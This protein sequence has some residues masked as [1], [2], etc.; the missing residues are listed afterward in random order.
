MSSAGASV[1]HPAHV[2]VAGPTGVG[3]TTA[4]R[5]LSARLRLPACFE[6]AERNPFLA[7]F[8]T[9]PAAWA[10]RSQL[11]FLLHAMEWHSRS[12][13]GGGVQDHS[14]YEAWHVFARVQRDFG[15]LTSEDYEL[16]KEGATLG[17]RVLRSPNL[18]IHLVAPQDVLIKRIGTRGRCHE[19]AL[20]PSYFAALDRRQEAL[21]DQWTR[22]P[23]IT[24]DTSEVDLRTPAGI[25]ALVERIR[26]ISPLIASFERHV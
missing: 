23:I 11:W 16:L 9:D 26:S 17:D 12:M 21:F 22:S 19:R 2:I 4:A 25:E 15:Y 24:I 8:S 10:F 5:G 1:D 3:K 18:V 6:E 13:V 20:A 14:Y 7:R